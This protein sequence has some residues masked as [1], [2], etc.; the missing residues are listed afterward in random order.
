MLLR[1]PCRVCLLIIRLWYDFYS[2]FGNVHELTNRKMTLSDNPFCSV[3][4]LIAL[5]SFSL[6]V[7]YLLK[8]KTF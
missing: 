1:Y 8:E 4:F 2:S 7:H 5:L 3:I 6:K